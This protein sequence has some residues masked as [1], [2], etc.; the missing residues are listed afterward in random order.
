MSQILR[1]ASVL[2]ASHSPKSKNLNKKEL[3]YRKVPFFVL[4]FVDFKDLKC[5][6]ISDIDMINSR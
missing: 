6:N 4:F 2:T 5:Y 1:F 3:F